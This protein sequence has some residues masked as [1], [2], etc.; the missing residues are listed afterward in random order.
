MVTLLFTIGS[1]II[2]TLLFADILHSLII[3]DFILLD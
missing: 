3:G 2:G 1:L